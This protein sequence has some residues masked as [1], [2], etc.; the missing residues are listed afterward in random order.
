MTPLTS[1]HD[2]KL[3]P[4][5]PDMKRLSIDYQHLRGRFINNME[6]W[7]RVL[8]TI[9]RLNKNIKTLGENSK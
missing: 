7:P 4:S 3:L 8:M 9:N 5:A 6:P 1:V 2:V